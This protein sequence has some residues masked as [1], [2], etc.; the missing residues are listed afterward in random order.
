M[1]KTYDSFILLARK[2]IDARTTLSVNLEKNV[3]KTIKN[4]RAAITE[5][6][7]KFLREH[8][9]QVARGLKTEEKVEFY[10]DEYKKTHDALVKFDQKNK[11]KK[12]GKGV[13]SKEERIARERFKMINNS[14]RRRTK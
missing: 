9:L 14:F 13:L 10:F 2:E 7:Q 1:E 6:N 3:V 8:T 4:T 11:P 12:S 5:R